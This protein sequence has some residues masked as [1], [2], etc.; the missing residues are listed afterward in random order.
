MNKIATSRYASAPAL[1]L[2]LGATIDGRFCRAFFPRTH[3]AGPCH[4]PVGFRLAGYD[5]DDPIIGLSWR[6]PNARHLGRRVVV[7]DRPWA[8][9]VVY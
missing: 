6:L 9:Q 3:I 8:R 5:H 7:L 1:T 4:A 2:A